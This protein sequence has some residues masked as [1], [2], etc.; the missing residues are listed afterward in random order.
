MPS[1]ES[2]IMVLEILCDFNH[3]AII[4][5]IDMVIFTAQAIHSEIPVTIPW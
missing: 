3:N 1:L 5:V 2:Q 4:L